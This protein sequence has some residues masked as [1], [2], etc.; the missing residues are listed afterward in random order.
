MQVA[1]LAD[2]VGYVVTLRLGDLRVWHVVH[3]R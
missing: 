3:L 2:E 1:M